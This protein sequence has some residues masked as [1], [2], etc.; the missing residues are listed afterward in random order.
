MWAELIRDRGGTPVDSLAEADGAKLAGARFIA[1]LRRDD[2]VLPGVAALDP[3]QA[4]AHLTL[5]DTGP[6]V[7]R[8][9]G[10]NRFLARL[11]AS[12]VEPYLLKAG[13]VGG[14]D[15][16]ASIEVKEEHVAA[17]LN[18]VLTGAVEWERDPDFGYRVAAEVPGIE[19]SDRF[20]LIPRFLYARTERVYEYAAL[21]PELKRERVAQ[22]EALDGL[23]PAIVDA[24]R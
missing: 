6:L 1:V 13:R 19:G 21:V 17:I 5:A 10:A 11:Q 7:T 14:T 4:V 2:G 8:A 16:E 18:A 20:L 24:V 3:A 23:D 12:Q 15:P 9:A 22:L